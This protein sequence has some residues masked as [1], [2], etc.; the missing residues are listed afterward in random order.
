LENRR[1]A[2]YDTELPGEGL[3]IWRVAN[4]RPLVEES[5]GVQGPAGPRSYLKDVPFPSP[6]NR[7]FT[8]YTTPSSRS[9]MGGGPPVFITEI[10]RRPDGKITFAV[11]YASF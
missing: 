8:P 5:H 10:E 9:I 4:G 2:G 1:K 3:L 7:S 11:G 6:S